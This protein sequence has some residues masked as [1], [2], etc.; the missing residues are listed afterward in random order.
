MTPV[1]QNTA[2]QKTTNKP[3]TTSML[4]SLIASK[5]SEK[6]QEASVRSLDN[7]QKK[8][9][10]SIM[11]CRKIE[12]DKRIPI[13]V[14][15]SAL[16]SVATVSALEGLSTTQRN[17]MQQCIAWLSHAANQTIPE[18]CT[19]LKTLAAKFHIYYRF[20]NDID[21]YVMSVPDEFKKI[22]HFFDSIR[23]ISCIHLGIYEHFSQKYAKDVVRIT[24]AMGLPSVIEIAAGKGQ[25]TASFKTIGRHP[26]KTTDPIVESDH[27]SK[28]LV[29]KQDALTCIQERETEKKGRTLYLASHPA[30]DM[31]GDLLVNAKIPFVVLTVGPDVS[32]F[33]KQARAK[34]EL[35]Y[36]NS[37]LKLELK[38]YSG[39][40]ESDHVQLIFFNMS[41]VQ[42]QEMVKKFLLSMCN[43]TH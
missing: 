33:L 32:N 6:S 21:D 25:Q 31:W 38:H 35:E 14:Y 16:Q 2:S 13:T 8:I 10:M 20:D 17:A 3:K 37:L 28:V 23:R 39:L 11:E 36:D 15:I 42:A 41:G 27:Y 30:K 29:I 34:L 1:L 40:H 5:A 22:A 43:K 12:I 7:Q 19:N 18:D 9:Y 24:S 26:A 4:H